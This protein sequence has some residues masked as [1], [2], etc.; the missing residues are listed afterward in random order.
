M[1]DNIVPV[2]VETAVSAGVMGLVGMVI[3]LTWGREKN[4]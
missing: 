2:I 3:V 4:S 1:Y